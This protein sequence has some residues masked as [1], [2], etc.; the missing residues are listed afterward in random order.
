[1]L[2]DILE[3]VKCNLCGLEEYRVVYEMPDR[4]YFADEWFTVV[5]CQNCGLG[6]VNPRPTSAEML[7]YYPAPFYDYFDNERDFHMRRYSAE[8]ELLQEI[9]T[10]NSGL[11]LDVGCAN[12]DF[13]RF[14][15]KLG[16]QVE[17][18]EVSRTSKPILDFKVYGMEFTQIPVF[19]TRYDAVTAWAV[20][21]HVHDPMAYFNK[22]AEVLKPG[23]VFVFLVTNFDSI[24]SK[25][26]F[27][28]DVPRHLFFFTEKTIR[29]YLSCF[30]FEL[31]KTD[32]SDKIYSMRPVNWLRY[33]FCRY[34]RK[35]KLDWN[36][37]PNNRIRY[38]EKHGIRDSFVSNLR[39]VVSNPFTAI[40]RILMP[41]FEKYQILSNKYGIVTYVARKHW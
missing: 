20:L 10:N 41:L 40:D 33:Y 39:Y 19:E 34:V 5:E 36:G 3:T 31:L 23:G 32:Y 28:E 37:I 6:F 26:L 22:V 16:W 18:V 8:A 13:P 11:L 2:G 12:G 15:K 1:M 17:G 30:G 24:S 25:Y 35:R 9:T 38:L 4:L 14:M 7:R 21:E 29:K 27:C